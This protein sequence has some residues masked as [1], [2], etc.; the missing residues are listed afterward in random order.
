MHMICGI[1]LS[2]LRRFFGV[3]I[4]M[5]GVVPAPG[6]HAGPQQSKLAQAKS[7]EDQGLFEEAV[8]QYQA[9]LKGISPSPQARMGLGRSWASLGRCDQAANALRGIVSRRAAAAAIIGICNFR[10][11]DFGPAI[12]HL[13]QSVRLAPAEKG[14]RIYLSRAYAARGRYNE[15]IATLKSWLARNGDDADVLYWIGKFYEGLASTTFQNMAEKHPNSYL[16]HQLE[17]EQYVDKKEYKKALEAFDRALVLAP[18]ARG[19]HY[20]RGNVYWR[21]RSLRDAQVE[22]E[23]ELRSNPFHAQANYLLGDIYVTLREPD[24]AIPFLERA[25]TLN[26]GIWDAHRS[27]GRAFVTNNRIQEAVRE[28]QIVAKANPNDDTIHGLLSNAYRRLGDMASAIE[29]GKLYQKLNAARRARVPKPSVDN[30][31]ETAP[32]E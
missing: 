32:L 17:G 26:P 5:F 11:H 21:Q 6:V 15:A 7:S 18:D 29:E 24:K 4:L 27:L 9:I 14:S 19:L 23:T 10:V 2:P 31:A 20:W 3:S 1:K 25:I 30:P 28:F 13:E 22:F 16:V 12:T 8:D